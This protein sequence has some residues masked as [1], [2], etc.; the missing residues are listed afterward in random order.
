MTLTPIAERLAVEL[1]LP[2]FTTKFCRGWDS[3]TQPFA[4]ETNALTHCA[5]A[6]VILT[7]RYIDDVLSFNN[8]FH[9]YFDLIYPSELEIKDSTKSS[10]PAS[11][12]DI[13]LNW[14]IN[15]KLTTQLYY[16]RDDFNFSIVNFPYLCS[17]K[18]LSPANGVYV[19]QLI[20][21]NTSAYDQFLSRGKVV[22]GVSTVTFEGSKS[23]ILWLI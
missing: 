19:S 23:Q 22:A 15:G 7:F 21:W 16:K 4:C 20:R 18:P 2:V 3:N 12:L 6:A 8:N 9:S 1:S 13:F 14:D 11:Y 17:N 5:I 10:M